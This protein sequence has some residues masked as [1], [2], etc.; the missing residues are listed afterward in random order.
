MELS[1]QPG[2]NIVPTV[3]CFTRPGS[4]QLVNDFADGLQAD[5]E[6]VRALEA[7]GLFE[8]HTTA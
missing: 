7:H 4:V 5:Y 2:S 3:D 6:R 1:I 8:V